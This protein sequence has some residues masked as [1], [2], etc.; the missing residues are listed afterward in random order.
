[1][2]T[3]THPAAP[4]A[5]RE[6]LDL[7]RLLAHLCDAAQPSMTEARAAWLAQAPALAECIGTQAAHLC[8]T[9]AEQEAPTEAD[10]TR[11]LHLLGN[12]FALMAGLATVGDTMARSHQRLKAQREARTA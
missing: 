2:T 3:K 6:P 7:S 4:D 12:V 11:T 9:L 5:I 1:M 10:T 8:D